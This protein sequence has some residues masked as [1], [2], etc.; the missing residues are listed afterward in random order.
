MNVFI[1]IRALL[2]CTYGNIIGPEDIKIEKSPVAGSGSIFRNMLPSL[3]F[4]AH[5]PFITFDAL[6]F[7]QC[8]SL[9]LDASLMTKIKS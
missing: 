6:M 1:E 9:E 4:S 5:I 7:G 2:T 3:E 8:Q